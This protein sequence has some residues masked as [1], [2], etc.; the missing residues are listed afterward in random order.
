MKDFIKNTNKSFNKIYNRLNE[1]EGCMA[2]QKSSNHGEVV[3]YNFNMN[4]YQLLK[5]HKAGKKDHTSFDSN[6]LI[7]IVKKESLDAFKSTN[8][9]TFSH[10][11]IH[12]NKEKQKE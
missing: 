1:E 3:D 11:V 12:V 4:S 9:K 7:T 2:C 6:I 8:M 10:E 5:A